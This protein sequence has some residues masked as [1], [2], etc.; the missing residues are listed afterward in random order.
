M[1]ELTIL[2]TVNKFLAIL[3][4]ERLHKKNL[5]KPTNS[6]ECVT[7]IKIHVPTKKT[8]NRVVRYSTHEFTRL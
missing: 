5:L 3:N 7:E 8:E 2:F 1:R 4:K 6:T